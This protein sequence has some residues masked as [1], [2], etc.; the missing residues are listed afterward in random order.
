[1]SRGPWPWAGGCTAGRPWVGP[2]PAQSF[3]LVG[4]FGKDCLQELGTHLSLPPLLFAEKQNQASASPG[5]A[6][7]L[8][9]VRGAHPGLHRGH[10][11]GLAGVRR[12]LLPATQLSLQAEGEA[13]RTGG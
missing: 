3:T 4:V 12:H 10:R 1:M 5:S 8:H 9:Q 11:G 6:G 7:G 2:V 13:L